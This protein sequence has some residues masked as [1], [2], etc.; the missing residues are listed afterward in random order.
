MQFEPK[1]EPVK[2]P[3]GKATSKVTFKDPGEYT[4][5]VRADTWGNTDSSSADQCCWTNGYWKVAVTR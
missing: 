3:L 4:V 1:K 2:D 5:R